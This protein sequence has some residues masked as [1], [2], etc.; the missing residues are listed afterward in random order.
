[1]SFHSHEKGFGL[2]ESKRKKKI[3]K[4]PTDPANEARTQYTKTDRKKIARNFFLL[5]FSL[6]FLLVLS[7]LF[8]ISAILKLGQ[9]NGD[10]NH[11]NVIHHILKESSYSFSLLKYKNAF[12]NNL[13]DPRVTCGE[14]HGAFSFRLGRCYFVLKHG[15]GMTKGL[16]LTEQIELCGT[17]SSN[18]AHPTRWIEARFIF[19][20]HHYEC[21]LS[22]CRNNVTIYDEWYLRFGIQRTVSENGW[23]EFKSTDNAHLFHAFLI[24]QRIIPTKTTTPI[25]ILG[26]SRT[27]SFIVKKTLPIIHTIITH[28]LVTMIMRINPIT[29]LKMNMNTIMSTN[30]TLITNTI[31]SMTQ[32]GICIPKT[33]SKLQQFV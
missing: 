31:M 30:T 25:Q 33:L 24:A 22:H 12:S 2:L 5:L 4:P 32:I 15:N 9:R 19:R 8:L 20:L 11:G 14:K 28:L 7:T 3:Q 26:M 16:N 23:V 13:E 21:G 1:M 6:I 10:K 18:L 29:N 17:K 27:A